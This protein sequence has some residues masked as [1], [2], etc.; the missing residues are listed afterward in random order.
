MKNKQSFLATGVL[1][2][3]FLLSAF[4]SMANAQC[5]PNTIGGNCVLYARQQVASL[6]PINLT[7]YGAKT[8]IINHR[9]PTVGSVAIM[10]TTGSTSA[11]GHVA[12]VRNVAINPLNGSLTLTIQETNW[13]NCVV[14][15]RTVTPESRNI[16]GYFDPNYPSGQSNPK[17]DQLLNASGSA[18]T[19]FWVHANGSGY[20]TSS[21]Q[22]IILGGWCDYF[23]KCTIP[24]NVIANK[25]STNLDVPVT[26]GAGTYQLYLFNSSTG[27]TSNGKTINVY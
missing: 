10:P 5:D 6:P 19:Q 24:N 20:N 1:S 7:Y 17:T 3:M 27:K 21:V 12:V 9:F 23:G 11:N 4:A 14:T 18:G 16:E 13:G 8:S 26:L 22:G 15:T 25:S 2:F